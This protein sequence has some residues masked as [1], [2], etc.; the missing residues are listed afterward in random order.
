MNFEEVTFAILAGGHGFR[1]G[2]CVKGLLEVDGRPIIDWLLTAAAPFAARLLVTDDARPYAA[3]GLPTVRDVEPGY[4]APGGVVTALQS[5]TTPWVLVVGCDMPFVTEGM[6]LRL[7]ELTAAAC[8]VACFTRKNQFEPLFALYRQSLGSRW[9]SRLG[10][11]SSLR[12]LLAS[13]RV[14]HE[15]VSDEQRLDS[16]NTVADLQRHRVVRK[17]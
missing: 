10:D 2:G 15:A 4:G 8:D 14:A 16:L 1:L 5:A 17:F 13:V 6:M 11:R 7:I 3:Y 9:R 12:S